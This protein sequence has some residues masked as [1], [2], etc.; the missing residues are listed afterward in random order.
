MG[1]KQCALLDRF[2]I[3]VQILLGTIAFSTLIYKRHR[4]RPQRP[5]RIWF[6]DVSKQIIGSFMMHGLNLLASVIAGKSVEEDSNPCVWY[7]L[8]IFLDCTLG[9]FILFSILKILQLVITAFGVEGMQSGD[10]GS[11]PRITW[12]FKQL[13]GFIISLFT[14]KIIVVLI[15]R[16]APLLFEVGE[17]AIRWTEQST[18]LQVVFVMLIFPLIMNIVQFWLV[19]QVIKKTEKLIKL[20]DNDAFGDEDVF[21]PRD[22]SMDEESM[23]FSEGPSLSSSHKRAS[24]SVSSNL[25]VSL[26]ARK[27]L[28]DDKENVTIQQHTDDTY[29]ELK[30]TLQNL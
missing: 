28:N 21:L 4:E 20:E 14:M 11:P 1:E 10:Y 30:K 18:K 6:F 9:V 12:W 24:G 5:L 19:D 7:F 25:P 26:L 8:N 2:A 27:S 15:L 17:W 29:I 16:T 3:L 22:F 23:P 13:V